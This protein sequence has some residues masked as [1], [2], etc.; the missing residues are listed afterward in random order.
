MK[1]AS[2]LIRF[3]NHYYPRSIYFSWL[4][5]YMCTR[6]G[7]LERAL[8]LLKRALS[9][10]REQGFEIPSPRLLF[11]KGWVLFLYQ[12]WAQ[13]LTCLLSA[14]DHSP[15]TPFTQLL[16]AI[17]ACM[18]GQLDQAEVWFK[19]ICSQGLEKNSVEK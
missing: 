2:D 4:E 11:E 8:K 7:K 16:S 18:V 5:S 1:E 15:P 6:Q 3:G 14:S 19:D 12:E 10:S 13:S 9:Y 17:N